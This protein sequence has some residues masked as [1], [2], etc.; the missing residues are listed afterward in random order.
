M[1]PI[2]STRASAN[3]RRTMRRESSGVNSCLRRIARANAREIA[4]VALRFAHRGRPFL[5]RAK[6]LEIGP[7][8]AAEEAHAV[9]DHFIVGEHAHMGSRRQS[10][11]L[12]DGARDAA[13]VELVIPG[14][15]EHRCRRRSAHAMACAGRATSP[16]RTTTSASLSGTSSAPKPRCR[17]D[18]MLSFNPPRAFR[19]RDS[20]VPGPACRPR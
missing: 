13:A 6:Q 17:S 1:A 14:N 9:E 18:S 7:E 20:R 3:A 19:P 11:K 15:V 16:A 12:V 10:P 4:H 5:A 8:R 2:S